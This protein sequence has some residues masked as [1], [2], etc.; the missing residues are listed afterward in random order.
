[1]KTKITIETNSTN[2]FRKLE[3]NSFFRWY[4]AETERICVK[5]GHDTYFNFHFGKH[6][7]IIDWNLTSAVVFL[8]NVKIIVD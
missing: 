1:M 7:K 2:S 3:V 5:T 4:G 6:E 8:R